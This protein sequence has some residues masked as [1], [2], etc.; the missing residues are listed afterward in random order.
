MTT[1]DIEIWDDIGI[2]RYTASNIITSKLDSSV[3]ELK[4]K[5]IDICK[6]NEDDEWKAYLHLHFIID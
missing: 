2:H 4:R 6:K 3:V 5:Y 1:H